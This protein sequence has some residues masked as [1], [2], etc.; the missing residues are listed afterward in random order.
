M[1]YQARCFI[2]LYVRVM[3][4]AWPLKSAIKTWTWS[5]RE[6]EFF[7]FLAVFQGILKRPNRLKP[8]SNNK[9]KHFPGMC[10]R[11]LLLSQQQESFFSKQKARQSS[12]FISIARHI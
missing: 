12:K 4:N 9:R 8:D 11:S 1:T 2:F 10:Q 6:R 3:L 7:T 5:P